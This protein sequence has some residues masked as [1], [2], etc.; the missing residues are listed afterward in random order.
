MSCSERLDTAPGQQH[1]VLCFDPDGGV[2]FYPSTDDP[3][4]LARRFSEVVRMLLEHPSAIECAA[5]HHGDGQ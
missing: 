2:H 3:P 4:E 1:L 5:G